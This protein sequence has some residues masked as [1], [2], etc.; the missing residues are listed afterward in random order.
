MYDWMNLLH[1]AAAIVWLGGAAFMLFAIRPAAMALP[2]PERLGLM[3]VAMGRFF[4]LV[5]ICIVILLT[6]GLAMMMA[7][8]MK[9]APQGWTVMAALGL[10]MFAL[11]G[12][13]YFGPFRRMRQSVAVNDWATAGQKAGQVAKLAQLNLFLG[14]LAVA[15]VLLLA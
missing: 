6:S 10:L 11:F 15:A 13:L 14:A 5:W 9:N 4:A 8:G 2:A 7:A 1:I 12:H 3:A